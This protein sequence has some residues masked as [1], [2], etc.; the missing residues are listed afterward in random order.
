[1]KKWIIGKETGRNG[2]EHWQIRCKVSRQN[3][4]D[5]VHAE[6]PFFAIYKAQDEWKYE[7]KEHHY[8]S[9]EDNTEILKI[10][11]GVP[12][13]NQIKIL[14]AVEK[15]GDRNVHVIYDK[16]GNH[17][18]SWLTIYLYEHGRALVVPRASST[19]EKLSAYICSSYDNEQFII[20]D[21]PRSRKITE[22]L[23]ECIEEVKDGLVFDHRY[24][25][26]CRNI[27]GVKIIVFTNSKINIHALSYD[28]WCGLN[29]SGD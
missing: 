8:T 27:R 26:K 14:K 5:H 24:A 17:G 9:S 19:A 2:Y 18:K 12:K 20:I 21:I 25:G 7:R 22:E 28:R 10:R 29:T 3:F 4:F 15:Q 13:E 23:Y 1:M 11:Y 16:M 6:A